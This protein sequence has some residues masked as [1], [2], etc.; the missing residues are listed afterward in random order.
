MDDYVKE[1]SAREAQY[2]EEVTHPAV[3]YRDRPPKR[4]LRGG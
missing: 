4:R 1:G 2:M 3:A